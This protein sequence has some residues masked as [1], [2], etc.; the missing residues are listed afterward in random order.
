MSSFPV[1]QVELTETEREQLESW[2]RRH[3][4]AQTLVQP[5]AD[6]VAGRGR[7][8]DRRD[9]RSPRGAS[10]HGREMAGAVS[11]RAVGRSVGRAA[12]GPAADGHRRAG[13]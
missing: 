2:S 1:V 5:V 7:S 8:S 4:S 6:R 10:E 9:L 3:T 11:R 13:R 12:A